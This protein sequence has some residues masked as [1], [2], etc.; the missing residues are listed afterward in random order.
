M[1]L[2]HL[3]LGL[4]PFLPIFTVSCA[5]SLWTLVRRVVRPYLCNFRALIIGL[6]CI[7]DGFVAAYHV[8]DALHYTFITLCPLY[9]KCWTACCVVFFLFALLD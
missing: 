1:L 3:F 8:N 2:S 9:V 7:R 5:I 6:H 4:L